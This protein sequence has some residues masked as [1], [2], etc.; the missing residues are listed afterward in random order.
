MAARVRARIVE[1]VGEDDPEFIREIAGAFIGRAEAA[2]ARLHEAAAAGDAAA[3]ASRAH[4]LRSSALAT[5]MD[6]LAEA[7]AALD[8]GGRR[9]ETERFPAWVA[10]LDAEMAR[11][12][13]V[14]AAL[15]QAGPPDPTAARSAE[16]AH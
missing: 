16:A 2:A 11:A 14:A 8:E 1:Q 6:A 10:A 13:V 3:V 4:F 7:A 15:A 9:G 12:R 5:G